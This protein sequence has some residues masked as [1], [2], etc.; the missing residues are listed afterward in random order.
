M[1]GDTPSAPKPPDSFEETGTRAL[2]EALHSSFAIVKVVM[3]GLVLVFLGSGF[4]TVGTQEKAV[5]L[6]F[7]K[8]VSTDEKALLGP[9]PHWAFPSP[10]DEVVKI[11]VG[12]VQTI[13]TTVGWYAANID[14]ASGRE[15]PPGQSLDPARDGYAL[16][17]D[18]N[19]IHV[20]GTLRYRIREPGLGHVFGFVNASNDVQNAFD[21]ALVYA[22]SH[23]TV[24]NALTRDTTGFREAI[25]ARLEHLIEEQKLE[26]RVDQVAVRSIPPRQLADAF[27]AVSQAE[28]KRSKELNTALSYSSETVNKAKAAAAARVNE[29]ENRRTLQ[30]EFV[31]AEATNFL[32]LLPAYQR[33]PKLFMSQQQIAA[34]ERI[35][36]NAN[37][38]MVTPEQLGRDPVQLRLLLS[39]EREKPKPPEKPTPPIDRH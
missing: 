2:S 30:V 29:G 31:K 37:M 10:I 38:K 23:F 24:D 18:G 5:I 17:A 39:R 22:A 32:A 34:F 28:V 36:T 35:S 3:V 25:R 8:P 20:E 13:R 6:R 14:K 33:N 19:I 12:E 21:S 27:D 9:G 4:F 16:T 11:P 7:G 15:L 1:N 26:V